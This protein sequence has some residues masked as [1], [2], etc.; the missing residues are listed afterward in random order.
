MTTAKTTYELNKDSYKA[1]KAPLG[2]VNPMQT[3]DSTSP[4]CRP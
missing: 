4:A 2:L 3:L 1:L